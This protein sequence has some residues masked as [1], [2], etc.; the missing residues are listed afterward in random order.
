[1]ST[2]TRATRSRFSSPHTQLSNGSLEPTKSSANEGPKTFMQKW[3]EPAVQ[4]RP[5]YEDH[6]LMRYGVTE[7]MVPLG[8]LPKTAVLKKRG[9]DGV[10]PVRRIIL[11]QSSANAA[12]AAAAAASASTSAASTAAKNAGAGGDSGNGVTASSSFSAPAHSK[13][14]D[15]S[16]STT[17]A[18]TSLLPSLPPSPS[19]TSTSLP[20]KQPPPP[21]SSAKTATPSS[22]SPALPS[23]VEKP[24]RRALPAKDSDDEYDPKGP[25]A[26]ARSARTPTP[27]L[28]R[29]LPRASARRA[30]T[31]R[32]HLQAAATAA[33]SSPAPA[34]A[35][36]P[37]PV[38]APPSEPD[39]TTSLATNSSTPGPAPKTENTGASLT[40]LA[41]AAPDK[42][43]V[44]KVIEHAVDE[45]LRHYRYPTAW[46][47]RT[48]YDENSSD[49]HFLSLVESVFSQTAEDKEVREFAKLL[50]AKKR[51]GKKDNRA[52]YYFVPP[53]TN[54]RFTPHKPKPAPYRK[55]VTLNLDLTQTDKA[56]SK[57][58][59]SPPPKEKDHPP[60]RLHIRLHS[61]PQSQSQSRARPD[62]QPRGN[63]Q[64]RKPEEKRQEKSQPHS[65]SQ[66]QS[67]QSQ[68]L[69][70]P[71]SPSHHQVVDTPSK[72]RHHR[73]RRAPRLPFAM[74]ASG[75][76]S[77]TGTTGTGT[78][79]STPSRKRARRGSASSDSSALSELSS[80][81]SLPSPTP[82]SK[83]RATAAA[84]TGGAVAAD[85]VAASSPTGR[86]TS[87]SVKKEKDDGRPI[88]RITTRRSLAN[89]SG[90][91][92]PSP[93]DASAH[94]PSTPPSPS[95]ASFPNQSTD[96]STATAASRAKSTKV[97]A[98]SKSKTGSKEQEPE[99]EPEPQPEQKDGEDH[100]TAR[101]RDARHLTNETPRSD[102][103]VR[104]PA[105]PARPDRATASAT[106]VISI[107]TT[108]RKS[109]EADD[110]D[111]ESEAA[112]GQ[113]TPA[114]VSSATRNRKTRNSTLNLRATRSA[115]RPFDEADAIARS[116]TASSQPGE[117]GSQVGSRAVTPV[118][119]R[120]AKK[121]RTGLRVK[122]SPVKKKGGSAAGV[123]RPSGEGN[124]TAANGVPS[125]TDENDDYCS[126]CG[127]V[128]DL[129]CCEGCTSS[130]H[131][132][133]VDLGQGDELPP[134]W[135]CYPCR[136][137]T[138]VA[139]E[140]G[141]PF[142]QLLSRLDRTNPQAFKLPNRIQGYFD[143]V[144]VGV[145]GDYEEIVAAKP[146]KRRGGYEETPDF[147][148]ICEPDGSPVIC[149]SCQSAAA[150]NRAIIPCSACGF[151]WHL[152]CLDPPLAIPPVLR[153]WRCPAHADTL[154][155]QLPQGLGPAHRFRTIKDA[156]V[157]QP[158]YTRGIK[159]NGF[160]EVEDESED[161]SG[162]H[163]VNSFGRIYK[164]PAK[165]IMLDFLS[166]VHKKRKDDHQASRH[167]EQQVSH[168]RGT[169]S[170][171]DAVVGKAHTRVADK[172]SQDI[173]EASLLKPLSARPI[174]EMQ[175]ALNLA[176]LHQTDY[177][178][179][180]QL[181]QTLMVC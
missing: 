74:H 167:E 160:I 50:E 132:E 168:L 39:A 47:L 84:V 103:F 116:P 107:N 11:K 60:P 95:V 133:C 181:T 81:P 178:G 30:S 7:G 109:V 51:E 6:G 17:N 77:G 124:A 175:A 3:L 120:P 26:K 145:D 151:Y 72:K 69:Q 36:V 111:A 14:S 87:Q 157:I 164:L 73:S 177:G 16:P 65:S 158:A 100:E 96:R 75:G 143:G 59:P 8:E 76:G 129:V 4:S 110:D 139:R 173:Q 171:S 159:N 52:C 66:V 57:S 170:A 34:P 70:S 64:P 141:G 101:R 80:S 122:S 123:P 90:R 108:A 32:S 162:W 19:P 136:S 126:A 61:Q 102:S 28:R 131:F 15:S 172:G 163:D 79:P 5:S 46:A 148:K 144:K 45:A 58:K 63:A 71:T 137:K 180:G 55:L 56:K 12:A 149:H 53:A 54:S 41:A 119:T 88:R 31:P 21:L 23:P 97:A 117:Q 98:S 27:Q 105:M 135:F 44:S 152:D 68:Q 1:M 150:D 82:A 89:A 112:A 20:T 83:R 10:T 92:S 147:F 155:A 106:P 99:P 138:E 22:L 25:M 29:S 13:G 43:R 85:T 154:L 38:S 121:Q 113:S 140:Q 115:K 37:V 42:E 156:P 18:N 142:G 78:A 104:A 9:N 24:S 35:P 114:P 91:S 176:G 49:S 118:S 179:L 128:G 48:L 166:Q 127:N 62:S 67:H 174:E 169:A 134:E 40:E 161:D 146:A 2:N 94:P 153:T 93:A 125:N 130:F 86:V 165:G 33:S